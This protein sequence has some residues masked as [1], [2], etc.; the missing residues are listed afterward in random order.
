MPVNSG[1]GF[2]LNFGV[3]GPAVP[4]SLGVRITVPNQAAFTF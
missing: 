3:F 4:D 1:F 2:L